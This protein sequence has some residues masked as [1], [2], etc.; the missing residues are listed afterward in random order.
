MHT[1]QTI[2]L[3]LGVELLAAYFSFTAIYYRKLILKIIALSFGTFVWFLV[4]T[5]TTKLWTEVSLLSVAI[6][7]FVPFANLVLPSI[8]A[9]ILSNTENKQVQL[10]LE[11]ANNNNEETSKVDAETN[12]K[13]NNDISFDVIATEQK[14]K[15]LQ[16]DKELIAKLSKL[17]RLLSRYEIIEFNN[18]SMYL[19]VDRKQAKN[20]K[21]LTAEDIKK[22]DGVKLVCKNK[23]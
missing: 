22:L 11:S 10:N 14:I 16:Q 20:I 2:P 15:A 7:M 12:T 5:A 21:Y 3:S 13:E 23:T 9:Y 6:T 8:I 18:G 1:L 4:M 19:G 17:K